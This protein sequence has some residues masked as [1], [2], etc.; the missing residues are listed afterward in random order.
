[1]CGVTVGRYAFI[2]AGAVVTRDVPD[3]A[4]ML[5]N[6]ARHVGWMSRHGHRLR[7]P[8]AHGVMRCPESG[9]RYRQGDDGA[10]HCLDLR[11]D[12]P[13]PSDLSIGAASYRAVATAPREGP[14]ATPA[15]PTGVVPEETAPR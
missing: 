9:Y 14:A 12:E 1:V 11:E 8:D 6:P 4:L 5:G 15:T 10:L 3:Y 7:D 2:G 13:L